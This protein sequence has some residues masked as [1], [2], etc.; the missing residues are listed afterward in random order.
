MNKFT[1]EM[2][3]D[4]AI[5]FIRRMWWAAGREAPT[6]E[7]AIEEWTDRLYCVRSRYSQGAVHV[8]THGATAAGDKEPLPKPI[9]KYLKG[10]DIIKGFSDR[11]S[12]D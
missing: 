8:Y 12:G 2:P 4:E 9:L 10:Y 7:Q 1:R 11:Q 5:E 3:Q 6:V